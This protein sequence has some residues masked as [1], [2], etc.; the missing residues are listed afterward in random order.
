MLEFLVGMVYF[1]PIVI[2]ITYIAKYADLK[3]FAVQASR[4]AAFQRVIQPDERRLSTPAIQD[5]LRARFFA[6]G[7]RRH[8]NHDGEIRSADTAT[9]ATQDSDVILW[10]DLTNNPLLAHYENVTLTYAQQPFSAA[11]GAADVAMRT[12]FGLPVQQIHVAHVEV[13]VADQLQGG[14]PV[15]RI[16]AST[17][18]SGDTAQAQGSEGVRAALLRHPALG[19]VAT[20]VGWVQPA[21]QMLVG[22]FERLRPEWLCLRVE[23]VPAD[24]LSGPG[25][26]G[27]CQ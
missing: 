22:L 25:S 9:G 16:S 21:V 19:G 1:I 24:R 11:V 23:S 2:A 6:R 17:A 14:H 27:A 15:L 7:D 5:Q 4:Y 26:A 8:G 13:S 12:H 10:R 20:A 18:L 3:L